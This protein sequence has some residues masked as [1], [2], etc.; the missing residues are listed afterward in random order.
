MT[1][2]WVQQKGKEPTEGPLVWA[3]RTVRCATGQCPVHHRT[4]SGAPGDSSSNSP[5]SG[6]SRGSRAIIH[7][8]VRCTPDS[9]RCAMKKRPQELFSFGK[10]QRLVR[11]NSPDMSGVHRTVRCDSSTTAIP[12]QRLPAEALNAP[13]RAQ[14]S[15][16]PIPAHRTSNSAC[17]VCTGHPGRPTSQK[18][19]RLESNGNADMAGA[20]D[21]PVCTGLSGAPSNRSLQP[22]VK[23][24]GW[25][26]KYPNHP[27]FIAIQVF[28]LL[29]TYKS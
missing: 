1:K 18:L 3:H 9:V 16:L 8:T 24:G 17:P 2:C 21:C 29:T 20:P 11:Y 6:I 23:F 22:T 26:Y 4:V 10:S 5:P 28:Q 7:R 13:Q 19:Q 25:G 15:G 27:S 12:H 14:T